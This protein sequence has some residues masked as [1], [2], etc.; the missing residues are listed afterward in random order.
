M[1][2]D[3]GMVPETMGTFL[4]LQKV[5]QTNAKKNNVSKKRCLKSFQSTSSLHPFNPPKRFLPGQPGV[6][7]KPQHIHPATE[8][9][10]RRSC[11]SWTMDVWPWWASLDSLLRLDAG[12]DDRRWV[13]TSRLDVKKH[14]KR[15]KTFSVKVFKWVQV[16]FTDE[17]NKKPPKTAVEEPRRFLFFL[18]GHQLGA[19]RKD[20][21]Y[22][23]C[24]GGKLVA[25][26]HDGK[27]QQL[28]EMRRQQDFDRLGR[29]ERIT[30]VF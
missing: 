11:K 13:V 19:L 9:S 8:G 23:P 6:S 5:L 1:C 20:H 12:L 17:K 2:I 21:T 28:W 22:L 15:T 27:L 29:C 30:E 16:F 26:N 4:C 18:V 3:E 24:H 10:E 25:W 7:K 14:T